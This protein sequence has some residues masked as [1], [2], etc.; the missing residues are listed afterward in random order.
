MLLGQIIGENTKKLLGQACG[1]HKDAAMNNY[2]ENALWQISGAFISCT[3]GII[4]FWFKRGRDAKDNFLVTISQISGE[5]RKPCDPF[6]FYEA[7]TPRLE[8]AVFRIQPFLTKPK[9]GYLI[10]VWNL[11]RQARTT[12]QKNESDRLIDHALD[13]ACQKYGWIIPKPKREIIE[14]FHRKFTEI[15]T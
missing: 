11:Y 1:N 5:F 3:I 13:E 12:L 9:A 4:A 2:F 14:F 7:T 15:A 10:T 8:D 6:A